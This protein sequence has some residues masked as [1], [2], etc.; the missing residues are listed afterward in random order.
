MIRV[1]FPSLNQ[2]Y[3]FIMKF[4]QCLSFLAAVNIPWKSLLFISE[5]LEVYISRTGQNNSIGIRYDIGKKKE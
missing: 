4:K 2:S 5:V 3:A 1:L